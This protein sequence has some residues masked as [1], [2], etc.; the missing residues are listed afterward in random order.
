MLSGNLIFIRHDRI[1]GTNDK[2]NNYDFANVTLSDGLESF[3]LGLDL[4]ILPMVQNFRRG[5]NV[6]LTVDLQNQGRNV[7]LIVSD[8]KKEEKNAMKVG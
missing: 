7:R 5:D 4:S 8:I 6:L 1:Q 3:T 2:G